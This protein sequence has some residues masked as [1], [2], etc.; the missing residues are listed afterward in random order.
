MSVSGEKTT[1]DEVTPRKPPVQDQYN[2]LRGAAEDFHSLEAFYPSTAPQ[3]PRTRSQTSLTLPLVQNPERLVRERTAAQLRHRLNRRRVTE[4]DPGRANTSQP[5][6]SQQAVSGLG[7]KTYVVAPQGVI[8]PP[9][10]QE[11]IPVEN[12]VR[13]ST[14]KATIPGNIEPPVRDSVPLP[15]LPQVQAP[16]ESKPS[17]PFAGTPPQDLNKMV[18][19][20]LELVRLEVMQWSHDTLLKK[21]VNYSNRCCG[22]CM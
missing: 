19:P 22:I 10:V 8:Y 1:Q 9:L 20:F 12:Q 7:L 21:A 2:T 3:G 6:P 5:G 18:K 14:Q 4:S 13:D 16:Q 17:P 15:P 11:V